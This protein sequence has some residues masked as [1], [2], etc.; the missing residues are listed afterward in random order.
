MLAICAAVCFCS[1]LQN[2]FRDLWRLPGHNTEGGTQAEGFGEK[3]AEEDIWDHEGLGDRGS[4]KDYNTRR[5]MI[6][7]SHHIFV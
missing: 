4:G 6:R 7:T 5:S 3:G 2:N 1:T